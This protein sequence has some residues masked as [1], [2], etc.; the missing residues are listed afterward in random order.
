M[1]LTKADIIDIIYNNCDFTKT[2]SRELTEAILTTIKESLT[3]GEDVLITNFGKFSVNKKN[4]RRGRNLATGDDL[5][6]E[7]RKVITFRCS[8]LL[9]EKIN[10]D[11]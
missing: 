5:I 4:E 3:S 6:L 10:G 7:A 9:R 11:P 8:G 2:K 1:T